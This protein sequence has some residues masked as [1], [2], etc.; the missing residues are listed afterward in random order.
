MPRTTCFLNA[1]QLD[2]E[3]H[4][5]AV[6]PRSRLS[7]QERPREG[8]DR[9]SS[10]RW[11]SRRMTCRALVWLAEMNLAQ[12]RP[13][14][15]A[16]PLLKKAQIAR[17]RQAGPCCYGLGRV[18]LAKQDYA[19]AV[20]YLEGALAVGPQATRTPLP[21]G[22]RVSRPRQS[23]AR[24]RSTCG[25]AAKSIFRRPIRCSASSGALL[26]NAA[27]YET[28]GVAGAGRAAVGRGRSEP[29]EGG[30]DWR[31][32]TR[33]DPLNLGTA[34]YMQGD[35]GRR[36]RAVS[37]SAVRLSPTLAQAHFAIGV[38]MEVAGQDRE[39]IKAFEA[40]VDER[41]ELRGSRASV[42]PTR[43]AASGA[44]RSRCRSTRRC[45]DSD[46][47]VSQASF[48]YAMGLVR[49]GRYQEARAR[50]EERRR[51]R[52]PISPASRTRW[53][54]CS[55]PRPTIAFATGR[56]RCRS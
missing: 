54:D 22:P 47:A 49:L 9:S 48:G 37:G 21:A 7:V 43:F 12:N 41:P 20:K 52:F 36:A 34:L 23:R 15:A 8:D 10:R 24:P 39:A 1:Q 40:A 46:P 27:A 14:A 25:C 45:C 56:E 16:E 19:Q 28:R 11:R 6:L 32:A 35:R 53:R 2:A 42:L 3:R 44:S 17:T 50:L 13:D 29:A 31:P 55:L 51:R 5:V 4:A 38:L 33:S 30:R 26:Q 18:A